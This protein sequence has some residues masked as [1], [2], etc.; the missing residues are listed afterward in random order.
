MTLSWPD[1]GLGVAYRVYV[2]PPGAVSYE[3]KSTVSF[4]LSSTA[5]TVSATISGLTP[6]KY[7]A[8]VVPFNLKLITGHAGDV[9]FTVPGG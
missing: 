9:A 8:R 7:Q 1:A 6:G 3:L 5:R 2:R 4:V